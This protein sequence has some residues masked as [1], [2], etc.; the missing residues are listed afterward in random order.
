M[1]PFQGGSGAELVIKCFRRDA[2][3]REKIVVDKRGL[4][5]GELHLL[6][7]PIEGHIGVLNVREI[8]I[9]RLGLVVDVEGC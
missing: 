6:Y 4:V 7:T 1:T 5:F 3:N 8:V 9:F 2:A